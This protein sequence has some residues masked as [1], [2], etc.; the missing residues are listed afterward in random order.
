MDKYKIGDLVQ[1]KEGKT[2]FNYPM[3]PKH[4][5]FVAQILEIV[6]HKH[7]CEEV[8]HAIILGGDGYINDFFIGDLIP[9][10]QPTNSNRG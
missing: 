9:A 4:A 5:P 6:E 1:I 3:Y 8:C 10:N 2:K 7:S